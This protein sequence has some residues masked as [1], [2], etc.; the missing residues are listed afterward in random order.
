MGNLLVVVKACRQRPPEEPPESA[1]F[2]QVAEEKNN[3][4]QVKNVFSG[5]MFASSPGLSAVEHP[6]YDIWLVKCA[7]A[8]PAA[9]AAKSVEEKPATAPAK[10]A[11]TVDGKASK[12]M[13]LKTAPK[14]TTK[15]Q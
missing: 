9:A 6:I 5:W 8:V 1:A 15:P 12:T 10:L 13:P 2:L 14:T 4:R 11:K 7:A 3:S